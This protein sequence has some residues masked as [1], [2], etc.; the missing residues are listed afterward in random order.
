[1]KCT[2]RWSK[3]YQAR[4]L[5][6]WS[7]NLQ[8]AG[9]AVVDRVV[10]AR[11]RVDAVDA[12]LAQQVARAAELLGLRQVADVAGVDDERRRVRQR[13]DVGDRAAQAADDVGIGVLA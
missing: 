9:D 8:V 5:P 13:V 3:L 6:S 11:H 12:D 10:L 2:P 4:P 7:K 1:M